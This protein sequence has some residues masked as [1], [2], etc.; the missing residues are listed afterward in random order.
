MQALQGICSIFRHDNGF[1]VAFIPGNGLVD[2]ILGYHVQTSGIWVPG[3]V[4][5]EADDVQ[6]AALELDIL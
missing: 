2:H 5:I 1:V 6:R 4:A 3:I